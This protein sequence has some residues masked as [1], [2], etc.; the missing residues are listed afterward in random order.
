VILTGLWLDQPPLRFSTNATGRASS[1][2]PEHRPSAFVRKDSEN[3]IQAV[4]IWLDGSMIGMA[5]DK[6]TITL[7]RAKA[8]RARAL[9]GSSSTSEVIDVALERLIR[10][11]QLRADI[12][13]YRQIPPTDAEIGFGIMGEHSGLADDTDWLGLYPEEGP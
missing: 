5:R 2:F 4:R 13:A 3:P 7:D 11:E 10:T 9:T 6:V 1:Q 12:A 8:A